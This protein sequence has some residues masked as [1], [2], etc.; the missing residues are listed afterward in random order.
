MN[1]G[2]GRHSHINKELDKKMNHGGPSESL[3]QKSQAGYTPIVAIPCTLAN[4]GTAL[5]PAN[6]FDARIK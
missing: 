3:I 4:D 6:E 2:D 1:L 5:K